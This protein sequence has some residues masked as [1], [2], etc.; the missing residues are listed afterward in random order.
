MGFR[1]GAYAKVWEVTPKTERVTVLK[2]SVG[3]KNKQTEA[4]ETDFSGFVSVYGQS[5]TE[6]TKLRVGDTIRIGDCD[7]GTSK[8]DDKF[9]TNYRLYSYEFVNHQGEYANS[10]SSRQRQSRRQQTTAQQRAYMPPRRAQ[11]PLAPDE[12]SEEFADETN[13]AFP[14]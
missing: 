11:Q 7:V 10:D 8:R 1:T 6:A 12:A 5:A 2:L 4:W 14:F 9:F 3:R 13:D